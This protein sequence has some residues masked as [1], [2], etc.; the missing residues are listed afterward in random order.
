MKRVFLAG[1]TGYLGSYIAKEL[2]QR[3]YLVRAIARRPERLNK[4][5]LK[6][7]RL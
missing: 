1:I 7:T 3:A 5:T 6:Q 4:N 2:Q